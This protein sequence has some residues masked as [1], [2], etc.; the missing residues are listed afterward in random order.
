[1]I[2]LHRPIVRAAWMAACGLGLATSGTRA[3]A[4]DAAARVLDQVRSA[5]RTEKISERFI[6][7]VRGEAGSIDTSE[8]RLGLDLRPEA[9]LALDLTLG[10]IHAASDGQRLVV[11]HATDPD[12][13]VGVGISAL[14]FDLVQETLPSIPLPQLAIALGDDVDRS[15]SLSLSPLL[16][17][18]VLRELSRAETTITLAGHSGHAAVTLIVA[19]PTN[20]IERLEA[21]VPAP[22]GWYELVVTITPE[23]PEE[24]AADNVAMPETTGRLRVDRVADL[25]P[26]GLVLVPE[27]D[28]GW[29]PLLPDVDNS[30]GHGTSLAAITA[31][32][33][34]MAVGLIEIG[35]GPEWVDAALQTGRL[36]EACRGDRPAMLLVFD[37]AG[38]RSESRDAARRALA[39]AGFEHP[40]L[41]WVDGRTASLSRSL[42]RLD[43]GVVIVDRHG[44]IAATAT[45]PLDPAF[46]AEVAERLRAAMADLP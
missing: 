21:T 39:D 8:G 6:V 37:P 26:R 2:D 17:P 41:G 12:R 24:A 29:L 5:Y 40:P 3:F 16:P 31:D 42:P 27:A 10:P 23:H 19:R 20:R 1:M 30:A 7:E 43:P 44:V 46:H 22:S 15:D 45:T 9:R 32:S 11:L 38:S 28:V 36:L 25:R 4:D 34:P 35:T 14:T 33:G 18:V 13:F